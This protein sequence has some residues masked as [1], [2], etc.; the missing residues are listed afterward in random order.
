MQVSERIN[1]MYVKI[2]VKVHD[3]RW[4]SHKHEKDIYY[5][6]KLMISVILIVNLQSLYI[7]AS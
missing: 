1:K 3:W 2:Y 6:L 7:L 4:W 5:N